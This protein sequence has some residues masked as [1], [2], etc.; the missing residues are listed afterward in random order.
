MI[1]LNLKDSK[2]SPQGWYELLLEYEVPQLIWK[3]QTFPILLLRG[4]Y[5][6]SNQE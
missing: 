6:G 1:S 5:A 4:H 2:Y 3:E